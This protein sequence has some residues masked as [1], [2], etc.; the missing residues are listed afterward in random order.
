M[1]SLGGETTPDPIDTQQRYLASGG[2]T[3][4]GGV[5][6]GSGAQTTHGNQLDSGE[7]Q[8][9]YIQYFTNA[10]QAL[11]TFFKYLFF[12]FT[13]FQQHVLDSWLSWRMKKMNSRKPDPP[14]NRRG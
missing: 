13:F 7:L 2:V 3:T 4:A 9:L 8:R 10:T 6:N 11:I 1:I 12:Q 5:P 14:R